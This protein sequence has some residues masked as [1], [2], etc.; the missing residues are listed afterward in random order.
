MTLRQHSSL[1]FVNPYNQTTF[2][3]HLNQ[4]I[5]HFNHQMNAVNSIKRQKKN[6]SLGLE[7]T[8]IGFLHNESNH[9]NFP[10][11]FG[12]LNSLKVNE[13]KA[14]GAPRA[15]VVHHID[16]CQRTIA[17]KHLSQVTLCGVQAQTKHPQTCAGIRVRLEGS[18][19]GQN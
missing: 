12:V 19:I 1:P 3:N 6:E 11:L 18:T 9:K 13:G 17:R 7:H 8:I 10:Y 16:P 4:R 15:L 2:H 14:T 5:F